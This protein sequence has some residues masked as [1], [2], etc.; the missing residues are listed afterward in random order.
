M[1][2]VCPQDWWHAGHPNVL[3]KGMLPRLCGRSSFDL[4][5]VPSFE[6][7]A[8]SGYTDSDAGALLGSQRHEFMRLSL[9]S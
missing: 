9:K 1:E 3:S 2:E 4:R 8:S 7:C 6:T 5:K